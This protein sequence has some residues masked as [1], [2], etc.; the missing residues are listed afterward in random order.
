MKEQ[1]TICF[2]HVSGSSRHRGQELLLLRISIELAGLSFRPPL[3]S[4]KLGRE[5]RNSPAP[6]RTDYPP[7][8]YP[9]PNLALP[10][11]RWLL[12]T[13]EVFSLVLESKRKAFLNVEVGECNGR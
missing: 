7:F 3:S 11:D 13:L 6:R 4:A 5:T 2:T 10:V 12:I 9:P 1:T 8:Q